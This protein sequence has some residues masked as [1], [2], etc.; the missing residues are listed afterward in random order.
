MTNAPKRSLGLKSP[1][2]KVWGHYSCFAMVL[3]N[4]EAAAPNR[5]ERQIKAK[6]LY[7]YNIIV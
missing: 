6:S 2:G 5:T 4:T 1:L 7:Y 3:R